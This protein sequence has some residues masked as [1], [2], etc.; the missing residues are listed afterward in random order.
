MYIR[1]TAGPHSCSL[2]LVLDSLNVYFVSLFFHSYEPGARSLNQ[3]SP[4]GFI[5]THH[6]FLLQ[7]KKELFSTFLHSAELSIPP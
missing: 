1:S 6:F 3:T 7:K 4:P 2:V 5:A